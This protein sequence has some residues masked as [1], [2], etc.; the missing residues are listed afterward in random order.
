MQVWEAPI[1]AANVSK[2]WP[3]DVSMPLRGAGVQQGQG[4]ACS[5]HAGRI[6]S[7]QAWHCVARTRIHMPCWLP[8]RHDVHQTCSAALASS[9]HL[10]AAVLAYTSDSADTVATTGLGMQHVHICKGALPTVQLT[11]SSVAYLRLVGG[12]LCTVGQHTAWPA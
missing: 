4:R 1:F 11:A 5:T 12:C 3:G 2:V 9:R 10:P 7:L 8:A 6:P